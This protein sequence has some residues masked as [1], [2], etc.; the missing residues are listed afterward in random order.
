MSSPQIFH[1]SINCL[2]FPPSRRQNIP[3]MAKPHP[4]FASP[5]SAQSSASSAK[6]ANLGAD[7]NVWRPHMVLQLRKIVAAQ[8]VVSSEIHFRTAP[9]SAAM[10]VIDLGWGS[11]EDGKTWQI[12]TERDDER[13]EN[14]WLSVWEPADL[15]AGQLEPGNRS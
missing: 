12:H 9:D 10:R 13:P 8:V 11:D 5:M 2:A 3:Q 7:A 6:S 15:D 4:S 14:Y 1:K